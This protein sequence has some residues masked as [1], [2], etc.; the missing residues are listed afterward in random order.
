MS[1]WEKLK[2]L[3]AA[4]RGW[5]NGFD[6]N[7]DDNRNDLASQ[8]NQ[9]DQSITQT[10]T[11]ETK[12]TPRTDSKPAIT[13]IANSVGKNGKNIKSEV[14][15]V[16]ELLNN[17]GAKLVVDGLCGNGTIGAIK[18]FQQNTLKF[19]N[20]DG[21]VD[22]NGKTWKGLVAK[23]AVTP[24]KEEEVSPTTPTTPTEEKQAVQTVEPASTT[25][26]SVGEGGVNIAAEVAL[27]Q[28]L[29]N[30]K[31]AKPLLDIN[32]EA[33]AATIS[34]IIKF[35]TRLGFRNPDG[36]VDAGG[37]TWRKL[38]G[39]KSALPQTTEELMTPP[40]E[41]EKPNW[42]QTAENELGVKEIV[43]SGHNPR[44]LEYHATTGGFKTDE[45]PWCA[46]FVNWVMKTSGNG[47]TGSAAAMSWKNYGTDAGRP[48]YGAIA[49]F[50]YGGGKGHVGFVVGKQGNKV[51]ILGGNQSNMVKISSF[52][53]SKIVAY[54]YPSGY[55]V[56]EAAFTFGESSGEFNE[57]SFSTTR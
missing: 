52:G 2:E 56:P 49:V 14:K 36:R 19:N 37:S 12:A 15:V 5:S 43:G 47:G 32:G 30:E 24:Q 50:S 13:P 25:T 10:L 26:K 35:Q 23:A 28:K 29:L 54:V 6:N 55:D 17:H 40:G 4:L 27:V 42:M 48:G 51:L 44:V 9:L 22:P 11:E 3:Q 18:H 1:F 34:A 16:Q 38:S 20:C 57:E 41:M 21:R 31:G 33:D 8:V 46:S 39:P 53:T 7:A 45:V